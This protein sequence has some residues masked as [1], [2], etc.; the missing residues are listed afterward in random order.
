MAGSSTMSAT[1]PSSDPT[2]TPP[3]G[4]PDGPPDDGAAGQLG[5][6]RERTGE[7]PPGARRTAARGD[8]AGAEVAAVEQG[9]GHREPAHEG[10]HPEQQQPGA[11]GA[12]GLDP[13]GPAQRREPAEPVGEGPRVRRV[14][15]G[16]QGVHRPQR[17]EPQP[18]GATRRRGELHHD[19]RDAD[20]GEARRHP[21]DGEGDAAGGVHAERRQPGAREH[22]RGDHGDRPQGHRRR[23]CR[24]A[25][26]DAGAEQ[27]EAPLVLLGAGVPAHDDEPEHRGEERAHHQ[28]LEHGERVGGV[29]R[30]R[31]VEGDH[32]RVAQ[33]TG[34]PGGGRLVGRVERQG[35]LRR[36]DR[37]DDQP[38]HAAGH[39]DAVAPPG[40]AQQVRVAGELGAERDRRR[41]RVAGGAVAAVM[42]AAPAARGVT[43]APAATPRHPSASGSGRGRA[44]PGWAAGR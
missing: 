32:R 29:R 23:Q 18:G 22:A 28:G 19:G 35:R 42:P 31:A 17:A 12:V 38:E 14:G 16:A 1:E 43:A 6:E 11:V 13:P 36:A 8:Q 27:L 24:P 9:D 44:P 21:R 15:D 39:E 2:T 30:D 5:D 7:H 4:H 10:E 33:H 34:Q 20:H 40:Q 3:S 37:E 41:R 26:D 25:A